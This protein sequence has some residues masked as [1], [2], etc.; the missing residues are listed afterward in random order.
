MPMKRAAEPDDPPFPVLAPVPDAAEAPPHPPFAEPA[1]VPAVA[2]A[3]VK[4][5]DGCRARIFHVNDIYVLDHLPALKTCVA[6][7]SEAGRPQGGRDIWFLYKG[8]GVGRPRR[9]LFI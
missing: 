1:E 5:A 7:E 6:K 8:K 3:E 2:D 4:A 9:S